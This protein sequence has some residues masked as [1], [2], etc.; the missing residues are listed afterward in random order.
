MNT[1]IILSSK[2]LFKFSLISLLS[3]IIDFLIF[4]LLYKLFGGLFFPLIMA[5]LISGGFNFWQNKLLVYNAE[6]SGRVKKEIASYIILAVVVFCLGYVLISVLVLK[7]HFK[8]ILAKVIVDAILFLTNYLL[9]K[10]FIFYKKKRLI[11]P[12][13]K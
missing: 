10:H 6:K 11:N 12:V 7:L 8:T 5:R 2:N 1:K 13:V 4:S 9:Q 3:F